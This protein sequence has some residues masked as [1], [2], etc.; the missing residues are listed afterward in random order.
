MPVYFKNSEE[1]KKKMS[2]KK[3]TCKNFSR[4]QMRVA[5]KKVINFSLVTTNFLLF[6]AWSTTKWNLSVGFRF[7]F[8]TL[9]C[10]RIQKSNKPP[11]SP[12]FFNLN[13]FH[14][15]TSIT[16]EKKKLPPIPQSK[17]EM[18]SLVGKISLTY[19]NKESHFW[20]NNY[21]NKCWEKAFRINR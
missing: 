7:C 18:T 15:W 9:I 1:K 2:R 4:S 12:F 5:P 19:K 14:D 20:V 10:K 3:G 13:K 21:L 16:F 6:A 8:M 17:A 11:P